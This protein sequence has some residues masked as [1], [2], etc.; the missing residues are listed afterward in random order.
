MDKKA[1]ALIKETRQSCIVK[2]I[3]DTISPELTLK[4]SDKVAIKINLSG[5][6]ERYANTHYETV[7]SLIFYLKDHFGISDILVAEGSDGAYYSNTSTWEILYKFRYKEVELNGAKLVNLDELPHS[8]RIKVNTIAG[9]RE[10]AVAELE[11]DYLIS[12]VPPKTHNLFP[13]VMSIPNMLGF[14]QP[15]HRAFMHGTTPNDMRKLGNVNN[16][17]F[18]KTADMAGKNFATLLEAVK[19]NLAIIDGLY[20]MEGKGPVKGSP[21]FH[22]FAVASEDIVLAD[23]LTAFVM[24]MDVNSISYIKYANEM[25]LGHNRWT[26][27]NGVEPATVKFPYRPHPVFQKQRYSN[28]GGDNRKFRKGGKNGNERYNPGRKNRPAEEKSDK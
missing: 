17:R 28:G 24:G 19:P 9:E 13:A 6:R 5:P 7:E 15:E 18:Q 25:K 23:S 14:V 12:V 26:I 22:G 2:K 21:V 8:K 11:A 1:I 16:D 3:M 4:P 10:A 20:G 27:V